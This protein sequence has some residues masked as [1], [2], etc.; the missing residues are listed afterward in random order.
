MCDM[1][2]SKRT[3]IAWNRR[4]LIKKKRKR[5]IEILRKR[6]TKND[7]IIV[8]RIIHVHGIHINLI[9]FPPNCDTWIYI[10]LL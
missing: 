2:A 8:K 10:V 3:I 7:W 6:K 9:F 5:M 1:G 4:I